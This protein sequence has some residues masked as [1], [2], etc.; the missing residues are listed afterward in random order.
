MSAGN[1]G[2]ARNH[3]TDRT[4]AAR[5]S[6]ITDPAFEAGIDDTFYDYALAYIELTALM[7][8]GQSGAHARPGR[9]PVKFAVGKHADMP[10]MMGRIRWLA[11]EDDPV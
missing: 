10:R 1:K 11:D 7:Q 5:G 8:K 9:T 3:G 6:H 2:P 4:I